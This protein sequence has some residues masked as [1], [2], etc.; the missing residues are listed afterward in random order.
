MRP[1]QFLWLLTAGC[2][3]L[4]AQDKTKPKS[5]DAKTEVIWIDPET[6]LVWVKQDNGAMVNGDEASRYCRSLRVAGL[7]GWRLASI[8]E[9]E[10][11]YDASAT[12]TMV[13]NGA[14]NEYHIKGEIV[15]TGF[16]HWS[17]TLQSPGVA[18]LFDFISGKRVSSR[19]SYRS[20]T[21]ALCVSR[22]A[23]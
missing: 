8:D 22:P 6:A 18:W 3:S 10:A 21:R 1:L 13:V 19:I 15:L 7:S 20:S 14:T 4:A 12:A 17:A 23:E 2:L 9:L 5:E 11:I 16:A